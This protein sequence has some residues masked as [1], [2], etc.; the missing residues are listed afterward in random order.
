[1]SSR[2][3][4]TALGAVALAFAG[5]ALLSACSPLKSAAGVADRF[6]DKYYVESD[7]QS[8]LPLA[9]GVAL[10]RLQSELQLVGGSRRGIAQG[11]HA[12]S[13]FYSRTALS[14]DATSARADYA[15]TIRP[16]GGPEILR[17]AH[18]ELAAQPDGTWRVIRFNETSPR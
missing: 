5:S 8:A 9:S 14:A 11:S 16:Q 10:L 13:V 15:L 1:M 3:I 12:A 6:V 18:L 17:D 2:S 4:W 7:Q